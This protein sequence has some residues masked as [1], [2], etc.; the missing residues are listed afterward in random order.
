[1]SKYMD[2]SLK[3]Q[4]ASKDAFDFAEVM[5][6][7]S[8]KLYSDVVVKLLTDEK[9]TKE[10]ILD[11]LEWILRETTSKDVAMIF[12]AGH[13]VND[14]TGNF[15]FLPVN[16][17]LERLKKTGVPFYEIKTTIESIAGKVILFVDACHSGNV[18]GGRRGEIDITGVINELTSAE[19]GAV[20]FASST[21]RQ[22]SLEDPIWNNG[23]FTK[24]LVEGL[25]SK[26]DYTGKGKITINMLELY[27]SERVKE[28]TKGR[29]TPTVTK[30]KT[31]PD[32]PITILK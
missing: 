25:S 29:Q 15:Y 17:D 32:F 20:V 19:N 14:P 3:L 7:Q 18:M 8:G 12:F 24:A 30:P 16:V 10:E 22:Y 23:A 31:I 26:A 5:K 27:I 11:G 9:A 28:L 6:N 13:G 21:G 1:V 2:Q 4:F